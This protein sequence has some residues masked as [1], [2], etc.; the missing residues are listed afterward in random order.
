[1]EPST[2]WSSMSDFMFLRFVLVAYLATLFLFVG[3]SACK[4]LGVILWSPVED[5]YIYV[6]E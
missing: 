2:V 1:M 3:M 5:S 6:C 4:K